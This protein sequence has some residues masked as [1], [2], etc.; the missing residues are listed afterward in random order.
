MKRRMT[1]WFIETFTKDEGNK[2]KE[3]I[4]SIA[5]D[6]LNELNTDISDWLD[7]YVKINETVKD[8]YSLSQI[9]YE[10]KLI[11]EKARDN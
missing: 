9:K 10:L 8:W 4:R 11:L 6:M 3:K 7:V 1:N 5:V 2:Y